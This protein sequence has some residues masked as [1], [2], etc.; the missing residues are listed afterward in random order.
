MRHHFQ[1]VIL[2]IVM[3]LALWVTLS[4]AGPVVS[5]ALTGEERALNAESSDVEP[6]DLDED[7][8]PPLTEEE[9]IELQA[10]L[11]EAGY[12]PGAI[13][14]LM[15]PSTL[16]AVDLAMADRNLPETT[17]YRSLTSRLQAEIAGTDP[18]GVLPDLDWESIGELIEA[19]AQ[20]ETSPPG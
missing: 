10:A 18:G 7:A 19:E 5:D 8:P 6:Q 16:S 11:T 17:T 1:G 2:L 20:A 13:D 14:G 12:S 9:V 15:G 3:L 4:M